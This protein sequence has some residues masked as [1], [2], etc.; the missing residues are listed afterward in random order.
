MVK[1]QAQALTSVV[2]HESSHS[3]QRDLEHGSRAS[4]LHSLTQSSKLGMM[5]R[6]V[7]NPLL[8]KLPFYDHM[9]D[10]SKVAVPESTVTTMSWYSYV[11]CG[12]IA[13]NLL[14]L[15]ALTWKACATDT[16][17]EEY[18]EG[19][20]V[21]DD[22]V[23]AKYVGLIL[24]TI[25]A[26]D[27]MVFTFF[28]TWCLQ[29]GLTETDAGVIMS[30]MGIGLLVGAPFVQFL[31]PRAGGPHRTLWYAN[32][33]YAFTRI[34]CIG[35]IFVPQSILYP[36]CCVLF[37][38]TGLIW[39]VDEV[40]AT[41]WVMLSVSSAEKRSGAIGYM[42]G[43]RMLGSLLGPGL[44]GML[45][46]LGGL[47]LPFAVGL[48]V[49]LLIQQYGKSLFQSSVNYVDFDPFAKGSILRHTPVLLALIVFTVVMS[50]FCSQLM[51]QQIW[52]LYHYH[53]ATW[54]YGLM[55]TVLLLL[56][57]VF[58]AV[59]VSQAD[60]IMGSVPAILFGLLTMGSSYL[61]IGPSPL[62]PFLSHSQV[63]IPIIGSAIWAIGIGFPMVISQSFVCNVAIG[64][65]WPEI[66][67]SIQ[68]ATIQII[69]TGAALCIG[70][71]MS[72]FMIMKLGVGRMCTTV[73]FALTCICGG[74]MCLLFCVKYK[75]AS[76]APKPI[77]K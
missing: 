66:D 1:K 13:V 17:Q 8:Y 20:E 29:Q 41:A 42:V 30:M 27:W 76:R 43:G 45:F 31:I 64:A 74:I 38:I 55:F 46:S 77:K 58:M 47:W 24:A 2:S 21:E 71:P 68:L 61:I 72:T 15:V 48:V 23:V 3:S 67:A 16:P 22:Y 52:M 60:R 5:S 63:W 7:M 25:D 9:L 36:V 37:L 49:L 40:S 19:E 33:V 10:A 32:R 59:V 44:G 6:V 57:A 62:L 14:G 26:N 28:P 35:L 53:M 56:M 70:P 54:E 12:I 51:W 75:D 69:L 18:V 4:V 39:A 65:G 34:L 11:L 50:V 73:A